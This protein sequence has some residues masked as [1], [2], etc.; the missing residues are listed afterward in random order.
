MDVSQRLLLHHDGLPGLL[1]LD[2]VELARIRGLDTDGEQ[3]EVNITLVEP[4]DMQ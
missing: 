4:D 2:V 3:T 1:R